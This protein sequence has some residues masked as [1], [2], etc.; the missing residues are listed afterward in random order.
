MAAGTTCSDFGAQDKDLGSTLIQSDVNRWLIRKV[1]EAGKGWGQKEER[2]SEDEVAGQH[3]WCNEHELGQISGDGERQ[4]NLPCF[5]P[6]GPKEL[7]TPGWLNNNRLKW[8]RNKGVGG[9][10]NLGLSHNTESYYVLVCWLWVKYFRQT[11]KKRNYDEFCVAHLTPFP[12]TEF[13]AYISKPVLVFMHTF[14]NVF[15]IIPY[16]KLF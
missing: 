13:G 14:I 1:P 11:K 3:H 12:S 10:F 16:N 6:W 8:E 5:S 2:A 9:K 15:Q 4:G 7:G